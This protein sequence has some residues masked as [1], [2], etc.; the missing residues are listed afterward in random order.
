MSII[1]SDGLNTNWQL[2][3]LRG[4]QGVVEQLQSVGIDTSDLE[5]LLAA[6]TRVPNLL[7]ATGPG[8]IAPKVYDFS[9]ANVGTADGVILGQPI[10]PGETLNFCAGSMN[11]FYA[12]NTITY[13][14]NLTELVIIY[15][16]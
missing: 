3:V 15:N 5:L 4:L 9:V 11:N 10:K 1:N 2:N 16:S 13:N 7:R 12:P 8:T 14:G 6:K